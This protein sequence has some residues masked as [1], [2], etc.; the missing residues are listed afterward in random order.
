MSTCLTLVSS[1]A[2]M[3]ASWVLL[4]MTLLSQGKTSMGLRRGDV[5]RVISAPARRAR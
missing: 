3:A 4:G 5:F 2:L 1:V